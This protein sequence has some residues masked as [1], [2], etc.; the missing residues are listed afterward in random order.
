MKVLVLNS[1]SSS[2]KYQLFRSEDWV[3]LASG[4]V[5]RIGEPEGEIKEEWLDASG[6]RQSGR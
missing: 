2:I 5:S 3:A 6:I 1:G 4:S